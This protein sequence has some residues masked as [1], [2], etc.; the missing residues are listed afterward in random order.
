MAQ[1]KNPE[2]RNHSPAMAKNEKQRARRS[3]HL[4]SK[5][6]EK[7]KDLKHNFAIQYDLASQYYSDA[8]YYYEKGDY[9][10]SFGCSDYAYGLLDAIL[11]VKEHQYFPEPVVGAIILDDKNRVFLM[12]SHKWHGMY[13]IPG[14]HIELGE[15]I[16]HAVIREIKEETN[17]DIYG[18]K[19]VITHEFIHDPVFWKKKH[20]IMFDFLCRARNPGKVRLNEEGEGYIW[21]DFK[22]ALKSKKIEPYTMKALKAAVNML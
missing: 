9:F 12:R 18:L 3:L 1:D 17:L 14:G 11:L 21:M 10:T 4:L 5:L 6:L 20:F 2:R 19:H 16:E 8:K 13:C 15:N 22:K 7:C